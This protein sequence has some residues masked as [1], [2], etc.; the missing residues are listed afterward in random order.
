VG[1]KEVSDYEEDSFVPD[2]FIESDGVCD[3]SCNEDEEA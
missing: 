3:D 1:S 2:N